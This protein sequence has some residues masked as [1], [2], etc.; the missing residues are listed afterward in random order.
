MTF[1]TS[2]ITLNGDFR[3]CK[4]ILLAHFYSKEIDY[5]LNDV[6]SQSNSIDEESNK[7][8]RPKTQL[9]QCSSDFNNKDILISSQLSSP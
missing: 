1:K 6:Q 8:K 7:L 4:N 9:K 3:P 2:K 5:V